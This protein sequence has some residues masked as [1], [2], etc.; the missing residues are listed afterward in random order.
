MI[1]MKCSEE[2]VCFERGK[3]S[4]RLTQRLAPIEFVS[5]VQEEKEKD[6]EKED[7]SESEQE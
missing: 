3:G 1:G 4:F 5:K 6:S 7:D 2:S